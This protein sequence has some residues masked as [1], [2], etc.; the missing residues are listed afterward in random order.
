MTSS[1]CNPLALIE[2][3]ESTLIVD[4]FIL[5]GRIATPRAD[6][7]FVACFCCCYTH[8]AQPFYLLQI[9]FFF[10]TPP[11]HPYAASYA[12][13]SVMRPSKMFTF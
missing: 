4:C 5:I 9:L 12:N 1:A 7:S 11:G 10:S 6:G 13:I 8:I 2:V 3:H